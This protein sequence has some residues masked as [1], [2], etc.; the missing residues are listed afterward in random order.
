MLGG[1]RRLRKRESSVLLDRPE[2]D[3]AIVPGAREQNANGVL[4]LV[5]G[6]RMEER[7]DRGAG[8]RIG[9]RH[10]KSSVCEGEECARCNDVDVVGLCAST[11]TG[12]DHRQFRAP[13]QKIRQHAWVTGLEV[14]HHHDDEPAP[15]WDVP[16]E[17]LQGLE[18]TGRG[19]KTNKEQALRSA[20]ERSPTRGPFSRLASHGRPSSRPGGSNCMRTGE[21]MHDSTLASRGR[22]RIILMT[23]SGARTCSPSWSGV[24]LIDATSAGSAGTFS[25]RTS[26]NAD[27]PL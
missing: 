1:L 9:P 17:L 18:P 15:C 16:E 21:Y 20:L 24:P 27:L 7:V 22:G 3:G 19:S 4:A 14:L 2:T 13:S 12:L 23:N 25:R 26:E 8:R 5:V 10:M 6:E 11:I